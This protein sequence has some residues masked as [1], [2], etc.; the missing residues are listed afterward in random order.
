MDEVTRDF[1]NNSNAV[2]MRSYIPLTQKRYEF[3]CVP[4]RKHY[5]W[6]DWGDRPSWIFQYSALFQVI[7]LYFF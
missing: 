7:V 4:I 1:H 2:H 3:I 6:E 5:W